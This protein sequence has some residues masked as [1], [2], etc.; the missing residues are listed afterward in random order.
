MDFTIEQTK[1]EGQGRSTPNYL[2]AFGAGI[3]AAIV[4]SPVHRLVVAA[5]YDG[6]Y[7]W[8]IPILLLLVGVAVGFAMRGAG[9]GQAD[10]ILAILAGL[11][12]LI[13]CLL[14]E[15]L[16]YHFMVNQ[17]RIA[18]GLGKVLLFQ[19]PM[20]ILLL[21]LEY[22]SLNTFSLA[23]SVISAGAAVYL[24]AKRDIW[25]GVRWSADAGKRGF[26]VFSK[27]AQQ[28]PAPAV[29]TAFDAPPTSGIVVPEGA[30]DL[31]SPIREYGP[32][33]WK[34][35]SIT[36]LST[37]MLL[38]VI[39]AAFFSMG[40]EDIFTPML[41]VAPFTGFEVYLLVLLFNSLNNQI[42]IFENGISISQR[43]KDYLFRWED[44]E[45]VYH[46]KQVHQQGLIPI[47]T[48]HTY[49]L[50]HRDGSEVL[51]RRWY[52]KINELGSTIHE[53]ATERQIPRAIE[54]L[55]R[56]E[57][58]DF[59]TMSITR[60]G[61][62]FNNKKKTFIPWPEIDKATVMQGTIRVTR[63]PR[64]RGGPMVTMSKTANPHLFFTFVEK[65]TAPKRQPGA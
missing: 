10:F 39:Y 20:I 55:R 54:T 58:L 26:P 51:I 62:H 32:A 43:G 17:Y 40:A 48:K 1:E 64:G 60:E 38:F 53:A 45:K 7:F 8:D 33:L 28:A 13:G 16:L 30:Y 11:V 57:S 3:L 59:E 63:K 44:V 52:E 22:F 34:L 23:I 15:Y 9:G 21:L 12:A 49:R 50:C 56:G 27:K 37:A 24:C 46:D 61:I 14:S 42:V 19:P 5:F 18:E 6:E 36:L 41:M 31:G 29:R 47:T 35:G 2:F 4:I 25:S 65:A